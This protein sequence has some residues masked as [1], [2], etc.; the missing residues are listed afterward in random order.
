M[1]I[2]MW[3]QIYIE[4]CMDMDICIDIQI[5]IQIQINID[6]DRYIQI[7]RFSYIEVSTLTCFI[8]SDALLLSGLYCAVYTYIYIDI[9][10]DVQMSVYIYMDMDATSVTLVLFLLRRS[11]SLWP[12]LCG[13]A[14]GLGRRCRKHNAGCKWR[15]GPCSVLDDCAGSYA[16]AGTPNTAHLCSEVL[17]KGDLQLLS[18]RSK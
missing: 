3:L 5:Q 18:N 8:C 1:N 16:H 2:H 10:I 12:I 14:R 4:T 9:D 11:A 15:G 7:Y 13:S 17:L 6:L